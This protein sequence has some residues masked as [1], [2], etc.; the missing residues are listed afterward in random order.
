MGGRPQRHVLAEDPVPDV[1]ERQRRQAERRADDQQHAADRHRASR[2]DAHPGRARA[3]WSCASPRHSTPAANVPKKPNS[4]GQWP[5]LPSGPVVAPV[6]DVVADVP[7]AAA[8]H[9][10]QRDDPDEGRQRGPRRQPEDER[11]RRAGAREQRVRPRR[12]ASTSHSSAA[13]AAAVEQRSA[14]RAGRAGP[15]RPTKPRR[16]SRGWGAGRTTFLRCCSFNTVA[17]SG[18]ERHGHQAQVRPAAPPAGAQG[19]AARH[20]PGDHRPRRA[21]RRSRS[22]RSPAGRGEQ[23]GGLRRVARPG[24]AAQRTCTGA[25]SSAP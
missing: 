15:R 20:R 7:E 1:V 18:G 10:Q 3:S 17:L 16:R 8:H 21:T 23:A 13:R 5:G 6:V 12:C 25:R 22:T 9:R 11:G 2:G 4:S 19:A 14:P 24:R